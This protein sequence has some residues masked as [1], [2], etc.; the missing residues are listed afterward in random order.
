[1]DNIVVKNDISFFVEHVPFLDRIRNRSFL[2]TGATG[3]IGSTLIKC[4]LATNE[5]YDANIKIV[6]MARNQ[7][8]AKTI[9]GESP[10]QLI[11]QDMSQPLFG[12]GF[13]IDYIVHCA[14]STS[15]KFYVEHPV[16]NI[17][18]AYLGTNNVL[19]FAKDNNVKSVVYLSSLECYGTVDD[20]KE[21]TED[22]MGYITPT[23][24][25]SSYSLGK[26]ATECLCHCY[27]KEY[28]VPVKMARL[29]Q[30]FGAGVSLEDNRVF[31]Q[32]AKS[33][34]K[35]EDIIL[36]TNGESAKPYC[37]TIDCICAILYLLM[38]GEN[39]EA[40]NVANSET[41]ISIYDMAKFLVDN[42]NPKC[43]AKIELNDNMGYA[44]VTHLNLKTEK[45]Q[46]LGW[47]PYYGLKEMYGQL[48]NYYK[49]IL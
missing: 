30:T 11:Y 45:L 13:T 15:S 24:V 44:P 34:I 18:T 6:A 39:G 12:L 32:F 14:N 5:K 33:I 20:D 2:V 40:Y 3:L 10:V 31:A 1:M 29:T 23:D 47:T 42:F 7:E 26:R 41:Y 21:I 25:R 35:G 9:F 28:G 17:N 19:R 22:M 48:I 4:L 43:K 46:N 8:K 37:Y 38:A 27:A 16:E 49:T 36:H